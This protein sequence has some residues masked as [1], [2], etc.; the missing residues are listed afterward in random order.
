MAVS[1]S[2]VWNTINPRWS[3]I[4][5]RDHLMGTVSGRHT[6]IEVPQQVQTGLARLLEQFRDVSA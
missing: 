4:P 5:R 3:D 2:Q 6:I 1:P